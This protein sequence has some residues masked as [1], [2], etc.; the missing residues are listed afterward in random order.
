MNENMAEK[1][2]FFSTMVNAI[3]Y[4]KEKGVIDHPESKDLMRQVTEE[5]GLKPTVRGGR[6]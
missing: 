2:E 6:V 5:V 4:A 3:V 1:A